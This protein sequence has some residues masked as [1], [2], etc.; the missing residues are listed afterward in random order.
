MSN[1]SIQIDDINIFAGVSYILLSLLSLTLY[2]IV[3]YII[4]RYYTTD[5]AAHPFYILIIHL[6]VADAGYLLMNLTIIPAY[7]LSG[8]RLLSRNVHNAVFSCNTLFFFSLAASSFLIALNRLF[9]FKF[10]KLNNIF[11]IRPNIKITACVP[12]ILST[13]CMLTHWLVLDCP[14]DLN[15]TTMVLMYV[16]SNGGS[17]PEIITL[18]PATAAIILTIF[19]VYLFA[20]IY[21]KNRSAK[22]LLRSA[23]QKERDKQEWRLIIQ[24]ATIGFGLLLANMSFLIFPNLSTHPAVIM[25]TNWC[26]IFN[27]MLSPVILL[28]FNSQIR[29]CIMKMR[30]QSVIHT[31]VVTLSKKH[32]KIDIALEM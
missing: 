28:L 31:N 17:V 22:S 27:C 30:G 32:D 14:I 7:I 23:Q 9:V 15:P 8:Q 26:S 16:C 13:I 4:Y 3:M 6:F 21:R 10:P 25:I 11:F 12:W 5:F 20:E 29:R 18:A 24:G 1:V 2:F 19:Y